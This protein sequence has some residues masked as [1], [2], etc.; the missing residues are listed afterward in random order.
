M[1]RRLQILGGITSSNEREIIGGL[2]IADLHKG[3]AGFEFS[4]VIMDAWTIAHGQK[5]NGVTNPATTAPKSPR[6]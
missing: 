3:R 4:D 6:N 5:L 2:F 1:E